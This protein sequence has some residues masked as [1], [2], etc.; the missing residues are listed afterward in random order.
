MADRLSIEARSRLMSKVGG[1]N[2]GPEL[3]VRRAAHAAGMRYRLHRRDLPGTPDIVFPRYRV[4]VFVHGCFWHGH[5]CT[6]GCLPK[7]RTEYWQPKIAS[8]RNRDAAK[9]AALEAAGWRVLTIWQCELGRPEDIVA[10]L[11]EFIRGKE[12][13]RQPGAASV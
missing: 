2:T 13:D 5:G 11:D 12:S 9:R 6:K 8:N 10:R 7:S 4:A 3:A 1:K